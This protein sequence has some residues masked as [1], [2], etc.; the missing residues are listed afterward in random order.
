MN[1][2]R[3]CW[4]IRFHQVNSMILKRKI[5][6]KW[7]VRKDEYKLYLLLNSMNNSIFSTTFH[8]HKWH[9]VGFLVCIFLLSSAHLMRKI[10]IIPKVENLRLTLVGFELILI[11]AEFSNWDKSIYLSIDRFKKNYKWR[12]HNSPLDGVIDIVYRVTSYIGHTPNEKIL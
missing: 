5:N 12:K 11:S 7:W 2:D 4:L 3:F 6:V 1:I 10:Q 8:L 9:L